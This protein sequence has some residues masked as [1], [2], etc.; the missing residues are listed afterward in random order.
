VC[1]AVGPTP[2]DTPI[3]VTRFSRKL[4]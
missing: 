2:R 4:P 3:T 1:S